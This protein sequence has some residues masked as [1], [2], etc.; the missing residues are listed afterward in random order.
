MDVWVALKESTK[1]AEL[2]S[3][4]GERILLSGLEPVSRV[5]KKG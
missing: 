5:N 1:T 3:R 4:E 2:Q